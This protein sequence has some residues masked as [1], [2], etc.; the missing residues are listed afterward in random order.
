MAKLTGV[1]GDVTFATG[2]VTNVKA[3]TIEYEADA[4]DATAFTSVGERQFIPGLTSWRG[5][6]TCGLDDTA[7]VIAPGAAA[8]NAVFTLAAGRTATGFII[9]TNLAMSVAPPEESEVVVS[10]VGSGVVNIV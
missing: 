10:F 5:T 1:A 7:P 4:L 6:Y 3:W 8:A 9:I 2:Y